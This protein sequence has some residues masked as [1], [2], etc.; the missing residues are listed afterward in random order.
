MIS[1][2]LKRFTADEWLAMISWPNGQSEVLHIS[3]EICKTSDSMQTVITTSAEETFELGRR[4]SEPIQSQAVF[5]LEGDLGSGKTTFAKGVA[6]G[7]DIDPR[8]VNSP[9]FTLVSEHEG[10]LKLYHVDLYRLDNPQD[11]LDH[12]GLA[13]ALNEDAVTLIEWAEKLEDLTFEVGYWIRFK[14]IDETTRQI[15]I[16]P[17]G[18][19]PSLPES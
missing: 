8:D 6:A 12:L 3:G 14:W 16:E 2:N 11:A 7:L 4:L 18:N 19:A 9:T 1:L 17:I 10:R 5:L 13:E 15:S